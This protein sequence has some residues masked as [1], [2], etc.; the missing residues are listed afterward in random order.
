M[1]A[2]RS[3]LFLPAPNVRAVAKARTLDA[4]MLILDLEDAV[5][6]IDKEVARD[7]AIAAVEEGFPGKIVGIRLNAPDTLW[8][9]DDVVALSR[10]RADLVVIPKMEDAVMAAKIAEAVGRPVYAMI[11]TPA[12]VLKAPSIASAAGV[13]GLIA[14][15][16]DLAHTLRLPAGA[17]TGLA[18]AL[19][20]IVLA[21]RAAGIVALDGVW[22]R[23][24]DAEGLRAECEEGG[25]FGF[26]GK[27]L[28]HPNQI[29][30][31]NAAFAP[32][33]A[34]IEDAHALIAAATSGAARFRGRMVEAMHVASARV[35]L[36]RASGIATDPSL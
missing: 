6:D 35:I 3:A 27:T 30:V 25:L 16:N 18:L 20:T 12:G 34:E 17:R 13:E 2:P 33:Q 7:A 29:A 23:L 8:H 21:A 5:A 11:E 28:I 4:D 26:D 15:T 10:S 22:N 14:G 9:L 1:I 24:D 32:S 31:A 19:Q 36:A